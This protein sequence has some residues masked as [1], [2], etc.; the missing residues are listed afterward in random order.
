MSI[1]QKVP[2]D[3]Q[4][5]GSFEYASI[6]L[7]PEEVKKGN[8]SISQYNPDPASKETRSMVINHFT[9]GYNTMYK[10]RLEFNDLSVIGRNQID[11]AA[12]NTYQPANGAP[13]EY[14]DSNAWR[15]NAISPVV[16]N[17]IVSIAA[18][19]TAQDLFPIIF[20]YDKDANSQHEA[21]QVM[22]DLM[23]WSCDQSNYSQATLYAVIGALFSPC[24]YVFSEYS[25]V[26]RN[27]KS[28]DKDESGK[29]K[30]ENRL[31]ENFSGFKD[32]V[33]PCTEVFIENIYE[34]DVQKQAWLI[35]RRVISYDTAKTKHSHYSNWQYVKP[36]VQVIF[37]DAN[38]FFY[39]V[40]DSNMRQD[41]V[42]EVIYWNK[43]LDVKLCIVN[44][45]LLS[46]YDA[47]NPRQDKQYPFV[48]FGYQLID[49]GRFYY[50]KS[51]AFALQP[52]ANTMNELLPM[53]VDGAYLS[54]MPP[55][56]VSGGE[57][58]GWD[59]IVPGLTTNFADPNTKV[60]PILGNA[61]AFNVGL[62]TLNKIEA[63]LSE[64]SQDLIS[65]MPAM[66]S[67]NPTDQQTQQAQ[68]A[69]Q[70]LLGLFVKMILQY[71]KDYGNLRVSDITQ[72]LTL[73]KVE[74]IE[75][76]PQMVYKSFIMPNKKGKTKSK[77]I[78]FD[79]T[80]PTKKISKKDHLKMSHDVLKEEKD[81]GQSIIKVSPMM[82]RDFKYKNQVSAEIIQPRSDDT[83]KAMKL[84]LYDRAIQ[85]NQQDPDYQNKIA[86]DFLFGAYKDVRD[87][88]EYMPKKQPQ[89]LQQGQQPGQGQPQQPNSSPMTA[90][91]NMKG[92]PNI[93]PTSP[94]AGGIGK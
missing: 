1:V 87:P 34:H 55:V 61:Q 49:Q 14:D 7:D 43:G 45:V 80:L 56:A 46:E 41:M 24:S 94:V 79:P 69:V 62:E 54:I 75:N 15:S 84:E 19:A 22:R 40:Y 23:E 4:R 33:V 51:M 5:V 74:M 82:F 9:L 6:K 92:G 26:Y 85:L 53:I 29:W 72:Y 48:K 77:K 68:Q 70:I 35:W 36:G 38:Q 58:V 47:P 66:G 63:G 89:Q 86:E 88:S 8:V 37:N 71:V 21:A 3:T 12:Y 27:Y 44:G 32:T 65:L 28:T 50:Y 11:Q 83:E 59:V 52:Q 78:Q 2:G 39:E 93:V 57:K 18:H 60:T 10:P 90:L 16:R 31:D 42:E 17:K 73:P 13:P 67:K 91:S 20:A 30:V 76:D 25:E 81:T 64:T